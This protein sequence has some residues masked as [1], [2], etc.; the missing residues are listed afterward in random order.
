MSHQEHRLF[1]D[2]SLIV[3]REACKN[4][5]ADK[6][7]KKKDLKNEADHPI[8]AY[9]KILVILKAAVSEDLVKKLK[10]PRCL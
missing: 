6:K 8:F 5:E 3:G 2:L 1:D 7:R 10:M 4:E 9:D